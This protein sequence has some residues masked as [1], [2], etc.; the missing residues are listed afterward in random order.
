[1]G[2]RKNS[3]GVVEDI[4][5]NTH[6]DTRTLGRHDGAGHKGAQGHNSDGAGNRENA[7][8]RNRTD[9]KGVG[10][11]AHPGAHRSP[12]GWGEIEQANTMLNPDTSELDRG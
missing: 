1:M 5:M 11:H 3:G 12:T 10:R 9:T 8:H 6:A 2:N 4:W 7:S